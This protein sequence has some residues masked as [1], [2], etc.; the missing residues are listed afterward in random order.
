MSVREKRNIY[1]LE[2]EEQGDRVADRAKGREMCPEN[3]YS[4]WN[5]GK[6]IAQGKRVVNKSVCGVCS[7]RKFAVDIES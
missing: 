1:A 3:R 2:N 5:I 4:L 6:S 7:H